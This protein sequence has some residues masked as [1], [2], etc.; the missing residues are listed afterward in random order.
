MSD[1]DT[2]AAI[3]AGA[4]QATADRAAE[5]IEQLAE[6]TES[7]LEQQQASIN[8]LEEVQRMI[9]ESMSE[10]RTAL[11][12]QASMLDEALARLDLLESEY[13][14]TD[15]DPDDP[16]NTDDVTTLEGSTGGSEPLENQAATDG[17]EPDQPAQ[18]KHKKRAMG[19]W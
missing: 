13:A 7:A 2:T 16:A 14:A 5:D 3:T 9:S 19:L 8:W 6:K 17:Q 15:D 18:G 10:L 4:A 11:E 1:V 12:T